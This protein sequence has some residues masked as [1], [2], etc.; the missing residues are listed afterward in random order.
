MKFLASDTQAK[1]DEKNDEIK[2]L[3]E[4]ADNY[5][6]DILKLEE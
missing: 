2:K 3:E 5:R 1:L 6:G 4:Y